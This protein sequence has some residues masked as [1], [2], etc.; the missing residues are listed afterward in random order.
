MLDGLRIFW[1]D[2]PKGFQDLLQIARALSH[3]RMPRESH[4]GVRFGFQVLFHPSAMHSIYSEG[5]PDAAD[6]TIRAPFPTVH[7][8]RALEM[9]GCRTCAAR[10]V[11]S[12]GEADVLKAARRLRGA[13]SGG[14][15]AWPAWRAFF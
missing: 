12:R 1:C 15:A 8:L 14:D 7:L 4:S 2:F 3:G 9:P 5:F 11:R 10:R 6:F 13:E